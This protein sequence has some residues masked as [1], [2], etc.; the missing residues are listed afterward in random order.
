MCSTACQIVFFLFWR[1]GLV[2]FF[3]VAQAS[4]SLAS[5]SWV[6]EL[7][8]YITMPDTYSF[9]IGKYVLYA[10]MG[11][12]VIFSLMNTWYTS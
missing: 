2:V 10:F 3:Y 1:Q 12:R 7:Q 9:L 5:V 8:V 6:L 4:L 11:Y